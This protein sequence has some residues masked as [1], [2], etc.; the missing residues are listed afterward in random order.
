MGKPAVAR[1]TQLLAGEDKELVEFAALP[2]LA[3]RREP[4]APSDAPHVRT[5]AMVLG[6]IGHASARPR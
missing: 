6:T 3:R 5:A 1:A 2:T 4:T